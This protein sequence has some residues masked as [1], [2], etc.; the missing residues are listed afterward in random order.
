MKSS[1][2]YVNFSQYDN[3]G[4]IL[5][6]LKKNFTIVVQFSF[7]HLRLKSGRKTNFL[8]VYKKGR[9]VQTKRFTKLRTPG[10]LLFAS[11]PL[12]AL[13]MFIQ[14]VASVI[15]LRNKYGIFDYYFTVN[16]FSAWIGICLKLLG[17]TKQTIFW[18]WDYFPV[19]YPDWRLKFARW[20]YWQFDKPCMLW[21]D[22]IVFT[23][24]RLLRMRMKSGHL[25]KNYQ[26]LIV[27]LGT[28][29][30][31]SSRKNKKII[32]GFLGMLKEHQGVDLWVDN[33][34]YIIKRHPNIYFEVIGSGPEEGEY[35][36]K[37]APLSNKIK[38][39]G[40]IEN[41]DRIHNIMNR[42]TI[43]LATYAPVKSNESYWGDPSKIKTYVGNG[44]PV[45]TTNVSP[46]ANEVKKAHAGIIIPY[47]KVALSKAID[48]ILQ[49]HHSYAKGTRKLAQKF[50]Y[51]NL[52]KKFF[53]DF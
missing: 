44:I 13:L 37:V 2:I 15:R 29:I 49:R 32:I 38:F 43:G 4:R 31:Q 47:N 35:R 28:K 52:Y 25:S 3:T 6:Y 50:N 19:E 36:N 53:I 21:S 8:K 1:I 17:Q 27:P 46:F 9:V 11:L 42:W 24:E 20:V 5:D 7:D 10:F 48:N 45:I 39:Y 14:T 34:S 22:K 51:T 40:F 41:Q 33:F 12:V 30:F 18:V 23:N 26:R 16:A